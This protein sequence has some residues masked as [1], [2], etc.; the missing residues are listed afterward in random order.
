MGMYDVVVFDLDV[1]GLSLK[2]RRFQTKSFER[3]LDLYTVTA[4][5]RI[6]LTGSDLGDD[7]PGTRN[8]QREAVDIDFHGDIRLVAEER[9]YQEYLARF[10]HGTLEWVRPIEP[11]V[12]DS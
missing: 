10:T 2:G 7:E 5:G 9:D 11:K 4:A 6:C 1:P 3:C 12:V 8:D